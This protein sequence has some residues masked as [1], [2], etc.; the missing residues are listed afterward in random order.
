MNDLLYYEPLADLFERDATYRDSSTQVRFGYLTL[1][2]SFHWN[3]LKL[4]GDVS[5]SYRFAPPAADDGSTLAQLPY[6]NGALRLHVKGARV[7]S[8]DWLQQATTV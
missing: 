3:L 4:L 2:A 6:L 1:A 8:G 7:P 5:P